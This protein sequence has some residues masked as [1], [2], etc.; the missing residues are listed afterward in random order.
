MSQ[1]GNTYTVHLLYSDG[2]TRRYM[3]LLHHAVYTD[4]RS[5]FKGSDRLMS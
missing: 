4:K 1:T 5:A 3:P 2:A